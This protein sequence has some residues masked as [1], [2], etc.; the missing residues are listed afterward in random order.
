MRKIFWERNLH[1]EFSEPCLPASNEE[2]KALGEEGYQAVITANSNHIIM[3]KCSPCPNF[4]QKQCNLVQT[5]LIL[6][7]IELF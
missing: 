4:Q 2:K 3:P 1:M 7:L 6:A 5:E